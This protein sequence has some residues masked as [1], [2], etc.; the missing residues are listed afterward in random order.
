MHP[1]CAPGCSRFP[2]SGLIYFL[3]GHMI[4][5]D[6]EDADDIFVSF[7]FF[8]ILRIVGKVFQSHIPA[9][10][11]SFGAVLYHIDMPEDHNTLDIQSSLDF[12]FLTCRIY[13]EAD[14]AV[15]LQ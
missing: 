14:P 6:G 5:G 4:N 1:A 12:C 9:F 2:V 7:H 3:A 10:I 11:H 8:N 13:A 15:C